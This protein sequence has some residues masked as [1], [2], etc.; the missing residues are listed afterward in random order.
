MPL[1]WPQVIRSVFSEETAFTV[2]IGLLVIGLVVAYSVWRWTRSLLSGM[3]VD[4]A[5]EGT[6]FERTVQNF[7]TSTIG[8]IAQLA[9]LFVYAGTV[10]L[11]L[12][13]AQLLA[14]D[15][16]WSQVTV[17]LPRI[18]IALLAVIIGLVGGDK[19]KLIV[20]D[21]LRSVKLPEA[22]LIPELVKYS[23][24]YIA[25]LV[26]LSQIGVATA[27]LLVLL[28]AYAFGVVFLGG[29]AFKDLLSAAAAGLF[30]LL[31]EPYSIGDEVRIDD[32]RGIVQEI[33]MFVTHIE[34]DG[35]EHI[36]PNQQ[37]F[38]SGIIRI[39]D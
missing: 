2:A 30:L 17:Y 39:R 16:F 5:V 36:I 3:G 21:H 25:A 10:I 7:G 24:F 31:A 4:S 20:R 14:V 1:S 6:L 8:I 32:K 9:A 13:V 28:G 12:Q 29:I 38:Q 33:D 11:A 34:A 23:I 26:A 15:N 35:E 22:A 37:V 19:A 18:F 27:A